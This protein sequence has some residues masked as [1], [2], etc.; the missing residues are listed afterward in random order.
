MNSR[1]EPFRERGAWGEVR[2]V[3]PTPYIDLGHLE[4]DVARAAPLKITLLAH[5]EHYRVA[6]SWSN[7]KEQRTSAA[8]AWACRREARAFTEYGVADLAA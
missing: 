3:A 6:A 4:L 1:G 2:K 5:R 7:L 8:R